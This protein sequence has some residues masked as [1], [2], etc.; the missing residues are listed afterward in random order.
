MIKEYV[1][2]LLNKRYIL[3]VMAVTL[4]FGAMGSV[5]NWLIINK[6]LSRSNKIIGLS[7]GETDLFS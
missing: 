6:H 4:F 3:I 7:T 1:M 5:Y 2:K